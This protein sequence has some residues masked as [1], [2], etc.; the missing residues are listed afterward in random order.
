MSVNVEN[1]LHTAKVRYSM[2]K[3]G[4]TNPSESVKRA[5]RDLVEKLS[6]L[7]GKEKIEIKIVKDKGIYSQYIREK[8]GEVIVQIND[9]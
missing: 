1:L 5:T 8:T 3:D 7:D 2:Q 9:D 6:E 4:V